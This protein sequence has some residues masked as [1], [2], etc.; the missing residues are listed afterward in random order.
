MDVQGGRILSWLS[1][2]L[3]RGGKS[4]DSMDVNLS[5]LQEMVRDMEAL[6]VAVHGITESDTT[7]ELKKNRSGEGEVVNG[8]VN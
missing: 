3:L 2:V 4:R 6:H 5:K 7:G 8:L 1:L